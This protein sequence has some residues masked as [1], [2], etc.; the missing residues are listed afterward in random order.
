MAFLPGV[1][2]SAL[3]EFARDEQGRLIGFQYAPDAPKRD[4]HGKLGKRLTPRGFSTG[5]R[6]HIARPSADAGTA[7]WHTEAIHKANLTADRVGA[8]ALGSFGVSNVRGLLAGARAVD[9][10]GHRL[11]VVALMQTITAAP[12]KS[13]WRGACKNGLSRGAGPLG[14]RAGQRPDDALVAGATVTL[15]P[16]LIR[17]RSPGRTAVYTTLRLAAPHR[18]ARGT[19]GMLRAEAERLAA[20]VQAHLESTDPAERATL[21][22]VAAPP[23]VGK[24]YAIAELGVP[25]TAHPLGEHNLAWIAERRDMVRQIPALGA[26]RETLPCTAKNCSADDLHT[27]VASSGHNTWGVHSQHL[28][29]VRLRRPVPR[30]GQRGVPARACAHRLPSAHDGIVIDECNPTSWLPEQEFTSANSKRPRRR[31]R[32]AA[33]R[34][35]SCAPSRRR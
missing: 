12:R 8:V 24:S 7:C 5:G 20:R 15:V 1:D 14:S 22:V 30:A 23:G 31:S 33:S 32:R 16:S 6:C 25:T 11:H 34:I 26:Y 13:P 18:D 9:P 17:A 29:A 27:L 35:C 4:K 3:L 21:L 2:G 19:G 28:I 10:R